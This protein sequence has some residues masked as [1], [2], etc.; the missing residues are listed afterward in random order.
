MK[1]NAKAPTEIDGV[2]PAYIGI[3]THQHIRLVYFNFDGQ[4]NKITKH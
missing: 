4:I 1:M 3:P 2:I